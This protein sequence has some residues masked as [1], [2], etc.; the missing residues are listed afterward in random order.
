MSSVSKPFESLTPEEKRADFKAKDVLLALDYKEIHPQEFYTEYLFRD[1]DVE[2]SP[3]IIMYDYHQRDDGKNWKRLAVNINDLPNYW[4]RE[5]VA[6]NPCGYWNNYPKRELLRKV[7]AFV[8]D[9][10]GVR[11]QTLS[12]LLERIESG[13]FPRPTSITNS[14]SGIHFFYILD[15]ALEVG[16]V[17]KF[18][19]NLKLAWNI[20]FRLH[21]K[22]AEFY[23]GVQKHHLGQDYRLVGSFTKFQDR[24][25]AWET[26]GFW[27]IED[28]AEVLDVNA[29]T[30]Y[31][32]LGHPTS[33][34][35]AY[36]K[37]IA[38]ILD[39]SLPD[40]TSAQAVWMFI[41]E[42]K[43]EA[44]R[45]R[46][47]KQEPKFIK[48]GF[49][50]WYQSTWD[51]VYTKTKAGNRFN[52]MRGLA[53]VAYK[54]G[55]SEEHFVSDLEQLSKL[56]TLE[57][58]RDGDPFNP[59]NVEAI[60][61]MFRNGERYKNTSRKRLEE[62]FGW[63]WNTKSRRNGL[64]QADHL[65]LARMR[66]VQKKRNG[67]LKN[68]EGRPRKD[69]LVIE[70]LKNHPNESVTEAARALGVSRPTVYKYKSLVVVG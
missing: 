10:D 49:G 42:N 35:T 63:E 9:V 15:K 44:H 38:K 31:K 30:V 54:S 6:V 28:L 11:P 16:Y 37:S 46:Q 23:K 60:I 33:R 32:P 40:M 29:E 41:F 51:K 43:D 58:W 3:S 34:M 17:E 55:I 50:S 52:A 68:P 62:L 36:A 65:E 25:S 19:E 56:W 13:S 66:K 24:A 45:M 18:H 5:D 67:T 61:R 12:Y 14:G 64:P 47:T 69:S 20:Y 70:Y 26:G 8:M 27:S 1:R 59:D 4:E 22:M 7:F 48:K 2:F 57:S 21:A 53:I 39:I